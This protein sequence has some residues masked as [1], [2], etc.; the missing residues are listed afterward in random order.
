MGEALSLC[1]DDVDFENRTIT[2]NKNSV[3]SKKRDID[4]NRTGGYELQTQNSTKTS[5]GNRV[6]PINRSAEDAL[7]ELQKNNNTPYVIINNRNHQVLP[8]NFERSF[9][10]LLKN[11][12]IAG[13]Y[14]VHALRHTFASMLFAKGV[15]VKIVSK[16]LGHS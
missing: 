3:L 7:R 14:G 15:D 12:G 9:H 1:W 4:G 5:N 16:L 2:V 11:A 6:I 10:A 8:S 13:D